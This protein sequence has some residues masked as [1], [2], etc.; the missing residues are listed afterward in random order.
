MNTSKWQ[1]QSNFIKVDFYTYDKQKSN[2]LNKIRLNR[3]THTYTG[4]IPN[5]S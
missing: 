2:Y 4:V 5:Y 3:H 1:L